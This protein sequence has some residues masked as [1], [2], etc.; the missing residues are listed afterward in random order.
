MSGNYDD[1]PFRLNLRYQKATATRGSQF[2]RLGFDVLQQMGHNV[3]AIEARSLPARSQVVFS[4]MDGGVVVAVIPYCQ[5]F[6]SQ[7]DNSQSPVAISVDRY[8]P[9]PPP[10]IPPPPSLLLC[11][12]NYL[13]A[14]SRRLG[15][16]RPDQA[17]CSC[18]SLVY[19]GFDYSDFSDMPA[20]VRRWVRVLRVRV[21]ARA[22]RHRVW[23]NA[24][25]AGCCDNYVGQ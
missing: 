21:C 4:S 20:D 3:Y 18:G 6:P 15:R 14:K 1:G 11:R 22:V 7:Y 19:V 13:K 10:C 9:P 17:P 24:A 23:F 25:L 12:C 2:N 8:L 5:G 16:T